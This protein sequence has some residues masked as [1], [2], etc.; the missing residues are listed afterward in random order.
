MRYALPQPPP[1]GWHRARLH[2]PDRRRLAPRQQA[3]GRLRVGGGRPAPLQ[4]RH[5]STS[6]LSPLTPHHLAVHCLASPPSPLASPALPPSPHIALPCTAWPAPH[7]LCPPFTPPRTPTPSPHSLLQTPSSTQARA[8]RVSGLQSTR[9]TS[10]RS[11][12]PQSPSVRPCLPVCSI[13]ALR[14]RHTS[15]E[16]PPSCPPPPSHICICPCPYLLASLL[17]CRAPRWWMPARARTWAMCSTT[18]PARLVTRCCRCCCRCCCR[19]LL[20]YLGSVR[21]GQ[22]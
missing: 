11:P 7:P 4:L 22:R 14:A 12:T 3:Q 6:Q 21:T 10:W 13:A 2:R 8:G 1:S 19:T 16:P 5:A 20:S 17:Q 15:H 18:A 9:S